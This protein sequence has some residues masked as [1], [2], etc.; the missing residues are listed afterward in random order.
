MEF[1]GKIIYILFAIGYFVFKV[2]FSNKDGE[3]KK[4]PAQPSMPPPASKPAETKSQEPTLEE[5]FETMFNKPKQQTPP[6]AQ[7]V[8]PK[9][10]VAQK[11]TPEYSQKASRVKQNYKTESHRIHTRRIVGDAPI[12]LINLDDEEGELTY[13][14]DID[15]I[16]WKDAIISKEILDRKYP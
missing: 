10:K 16:N 12:N 11:S 8:A 2:F 14:F 5:V 1:D 15:N 6:V 4:A 9:A 7:T 3:K 13:E